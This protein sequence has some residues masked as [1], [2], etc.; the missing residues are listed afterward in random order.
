M[1]EMQL[2]LQRDPDLEPKRA[3]TLFI[4]ICIHIGILLFLILNPEIFNQLP[5]RRIRIAGEEY[6]LSKMQL[7]EVMPPTQPRPK[8]QAPE[9]PMVAPP[10]PQPRPQ[11]PAPQA[12]PPQP[13]PPPPPPKESPVIPPD[14]VLAEGAKP[15][16]TP[17]PSRGNTEELRAGNDGSPE[18]PK[19]AVPK[20]EPP[21]AEAPPKIAENTNP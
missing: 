13:P 20:P 4:S 9:P 10:Q 7:T 6:D 15:D 1:T 8:P 18:S 16:G 2:G 14:A 3:K 17:K 5:K 19:P 21:K 11:P 12:A